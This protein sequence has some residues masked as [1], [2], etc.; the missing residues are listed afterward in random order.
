[1]ANYIV[2]VP[3]RGEQSY[4]VDARSA[5]EAKRKARHGEDAENGVEPLD[6][7]VTRT[8]EPNSAELAGETP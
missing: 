1:M 7:R 3:Y 4:L 8:Y 5:A 6:F 2:T